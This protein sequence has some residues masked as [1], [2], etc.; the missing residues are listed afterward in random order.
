MEPETVAAV[1]ISSDDA[2]RK[3]IL[4][5]LQLP[6]ESVPGTALHARAG[7]LPLIANG[8]KENSASLLAEI[9]RPP[10]PFSR[11]TGTLAHKFAD[12]KAVRS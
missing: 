12:L 10:A 11:P 6:H 2:Y 9:M 3:D 8:D 1:P 5:H 7:N 4:K